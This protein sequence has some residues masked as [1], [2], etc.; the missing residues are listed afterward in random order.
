MRFTPAAL[1]LALLVGVT[2]SIGN[3]AP[4]A[5]LDPRAA[6]LLAQGRAALVAGDTNA[7]IDAFEAALTIQPGHVAIVLN[8]A[9]AAR[10]NGMQGKA[11]HYYRAALKIDPNNHYAI[12]GEGEALA[13]KGALEKA[14]N[15]L[16]RLQ[17]LC[18][19]S[20]CGPA[21]QLSAAIERGPT[22]QVVSAE[23]V[24]VTPVV[25]EN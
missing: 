17:Q 14:R 18:G 20:S 19:T 15:N 21:R 4:A 6:D 1:A 8:L 5:P 11:L 23:A 22:P 12:A 24:E 25:S 3:S 16:A 7:A 13:E 2:S 10:K 9:E